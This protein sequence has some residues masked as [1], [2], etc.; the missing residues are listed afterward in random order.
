[1]EFHG[2][3]NIPYNKVLPVPFTYLACINNVS[4]DGWRF[5][6]FDSI[7]KT[8]NTD[9]NDG[10]MKSL[11]VVLSCYTHPTHDIYAKF[12]LI[13]KDEFYDAIKVGN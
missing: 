12:R 10:M 4:Q 13:T 2:S 11:V 7:D 6:M 3:L 5:A 8:V 1:M 9:I